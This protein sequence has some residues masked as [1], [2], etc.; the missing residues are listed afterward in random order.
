MCSKTFV[1]FIF[2]AS[3]FVGA[4]AH[5]EDGD[6]KPENRLASEVKERCD[7]TKEFVTSYEYLKGH[8]EFGLSDKENFN[9][10]RKVAEGCTGAASRFARTL[11]LLLKADAGPRSSMNVAVNLASRSQEFADTF[12]LVFTRSY[13]KDYLDL[14]YK[15]AF[16]LAK[17]LSVDYVGNPKIAAKDFV[18]FVDF[19]TDDKEAGL[20]KP[21]C[22][23]IAGRF[24][25]KTANFRAQMAD[26]FFKVYRFMTSEKSGGYPTS[27]ALTIAEDVVSQGPEAGDNFISAFQ[28]AIDHD[29]LGLSTETSLKFAQRI[30]QNT[31]YNAHDKP[32][33]WHPL[34]NAP[35]IGNEPVPNDQPSAKKTIKTRAPADTDS[36]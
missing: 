4:T 11:E 23:V 18:R 30:A 10:A 3:V 24:I 25:Q 35:A 20:S 13:L 21:I 32:M 29:G 26:E 19:C 5:A 7:S 16:E 17:R 8:T 2:S 34:E 27:K 28:Y 6:D 14:D 36:H 9:I 1:V 15:T 12:I 22:G 31:W 33:L